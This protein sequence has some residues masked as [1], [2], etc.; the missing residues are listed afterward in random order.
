M[1][2]MELIGCSIHPTVA[3]AILVLLLLWALGNLGLGCETGLLS[4]FMAEVKFEEEIF[5]VQTFRI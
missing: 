5:S 4:K 1:V 2:T 3:V